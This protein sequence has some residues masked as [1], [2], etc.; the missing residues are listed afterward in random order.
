[1]GRLKEVIELLKTELVR[2]H[3]ATDTG[4]GRA[5][6]KNVIKQIVIDNDVSLIEAKANRALIYKSKEARATEEDLKLR[7]AHPGVFDVVFI[8]RHTRETQMLTLEKG[9][10]YDVAMYYYNYITYYGTEK[11]NELGN[12]EIIEH[13]LPFLPEE[14]F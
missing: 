12:Y 2:T 4:K 13:E 14:Q 7:L 11:Y 3:G 8:N 1:M 5:F 9:I 10:P 6:S